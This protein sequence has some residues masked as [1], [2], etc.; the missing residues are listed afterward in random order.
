MGRLSAVRAVLHAGSP[1]PVASIPP[2]SQLLRHTPCALVSQMR[3]QFLDFFAR[4]SH[5]FLS[6]TVTAWSC[7][8]PGLLPLA[9]IGKPSAGDQVNPMTA[10]SA[11]FIC[12]PAPCL[13]VVIFSPRTKT[14]MACEASAAFKFPN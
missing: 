2:H 14:V 3:S 6:L 9:A 11:S 1:T 12:S 13:S 4:L 5:F 10:M 8:N 7:D